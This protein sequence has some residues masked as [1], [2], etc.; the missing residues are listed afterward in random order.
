MLP[1]L[2]TIKGQERGGR[3]TQQKKKKIAPFFLG[4]STG[5]WRSWDSGL[6]GE[7]ISSF[8]WL[9]AGWTVEARVRRNGKRD[10][11]YTDPSNKHK[12]YSKSEVL[13]YLKSVRIKREG[14]PTRKSS[15]NRLGVKVCQPTTF[16]SSS[17]L[18]FN[19]KTIKFVFRYFQTT[20]GSWYLFEF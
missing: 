14:E 8:D 2:S 11:C 6:M 5:R 18:F 13:R 20:K 9:P 12:F 4:G 7:E 15:R 19:I 16:H 10:K 17:Y 3:R 1:P